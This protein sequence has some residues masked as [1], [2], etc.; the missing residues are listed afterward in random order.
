MEDHDLL[1][2]EDATIMDFALIKFKVGD[3]II[4]CA[5]LRPETV[6]GVV[7]LWVN[8][9]VNYVVARVDDET[10]MTT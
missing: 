7:N 6:F 9:D 5:T 2:G 3:E 4:P 1:K 8:P 10:W